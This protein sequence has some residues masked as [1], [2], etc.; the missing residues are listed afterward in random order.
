[1]RDPAIWVLAAGQ[2]LVWAGLF[3]VFPAMLL[4]WEAGLGWS[5]SAL[6]LGVTLA[7][8]ASGMAAPFA[9][10]MI[11]RGQ[12]AAQMGL[13]AAVGGLALAGLGQVTALWQF[14][15]LS[16]M[17]GAMLAGCLYEPCFALVTRARG[18]DARWGITV[19]TLVAGFAGTLSFPMVH[20]LVGALGWRMALGQIGLG[21]TFFVAPLLWQGARM[22]GPPVAEAA[23]V[24]GAGRAR[25][26]VYWLLGIGFA[27]IG[28]VHGAMLHH[29][30][31]LLA[32]RGVSAGVAVAA[33][34]MIGPMQVLGRLVM[35][36]TQ[37][38]VSA[39]GYVL[40]VFG[41]MGLGI[42]ILALA[43]AGLVAVV[44]F[45]AL[46][47][48]SY[49][50]ISILRPVVVREVLGSAGFGATSG[51]LALMYLTASAASAYLG[52]LIWKLGGYGAMMAVLLV[53][54]AAGAALHGAA[55]R[56]AGQ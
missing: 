51:G 27:V 11:D 31:P 35:V 19:I 48:A 52:A 49:G 20:L 50:M 45:V 42:A 56:L 8:L 55:R 7:V 30:L 38:H 44:V 6:T 28:L 14:Y 13:A 5:R 18:G 9:G 4:H 46:F 2:T 33:V 32:E 16:V 25:T 39:H 37:A 41:A 40:G 15:A 3:Y 54:L 24:G 17:V 26:P 1:M 22:L 53:L 21:V 36:A 29:L 23:E 12:G 47:G 43:P 10:R 34:S